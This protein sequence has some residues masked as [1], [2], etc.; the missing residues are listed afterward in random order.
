MKDSPD[1][2]PVSL[3]GSCT[4]LSEPSPTQRS[5]RA[6]LLKVCLVPL[7]LCIRLPWGPMPRSTEPGHFQGGDPDARV[8]QGDQE[9]LMHIKA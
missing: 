5:L 9:I 1:S 6:V 4:M 3:P 8:E 7:T 2:R